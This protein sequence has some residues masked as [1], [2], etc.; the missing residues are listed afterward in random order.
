MIIEQGEKSWFS[1]DHYQRTGQ[2]SNQIKRSLA[3]R[4]WLRDFDSALFVQ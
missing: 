3:S 4:H 2:I 1:D